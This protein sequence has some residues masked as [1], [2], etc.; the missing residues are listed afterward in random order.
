[1]TSRSELRSRNASSVESIARSAST[2]SGPEI[3][4]YGGTPVVG[5]WMVTA[6][7]L[8]CRGD[9]LRARAGREAHSEG[10]LGRARQLE[11]E[12]AQPGCNH[13]LLELEVLG[14]LF[15]GQPQIDGFAQLGVLLGGP[16]MA[17]GDGGR[18]EERRVGKECRS[19]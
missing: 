9:R 11:A 15:K 16:G 18:S 7:T 12:Q 4:T 13:G 8:S 10:H 3:S 19:R 14:Q 5:A 17:L 2:R 6:S 1:M